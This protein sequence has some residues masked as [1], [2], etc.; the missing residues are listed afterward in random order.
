MENGGKTVLRI[1]REGRG[2]KGRGEPGG[3]A[4]E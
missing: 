2:R 3:N 1:V 4:L